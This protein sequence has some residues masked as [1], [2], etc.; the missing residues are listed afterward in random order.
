MDRKLQ[1]QTGIYWQAGSYFSGQYLLLKEQVLEYNLSV[2]RNG[3]E[4]EF[5]YTAQSIGHPNPG[6]KSFFTGILCRILTGT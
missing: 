2:V 3:M 6:G 5:S 1:I 4:G